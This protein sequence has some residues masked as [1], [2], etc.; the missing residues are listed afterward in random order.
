MCAKNGNLR[1]RGSK[2]RCLFRCAKFLQT[3]PNLN[4]PTILFCSAIMASAAL[5]RRHGSARKKYRARNPWSG[6]SIV[7][8]PRLTP[9]FRVT[10]ENGDEQR[11]I[12]K[13]PQAGEILSQA[14]LNLLPQ[15]KRSLAKEGHSAGLSRPE[16]R[17]AHCG[18]TRK[19]HR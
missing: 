16:Q 14:H 12:E 2:A 1:L 11:Q 10:R 6:A 3:S 7:G 4:K 9:T 5:T 8:R 18:P 17:E 19:T 13:S 15:G